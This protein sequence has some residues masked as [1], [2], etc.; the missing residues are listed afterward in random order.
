MDLYQ[1]LANKTR[2]LEQKYTKYII[3]KYSKRIEEL[4]Q[5]NYNKNSEELV[6]TKNIQELNKKNRELENKLVL[7]NGDL[8]NNCINKELNSINLKQEEIVE[9]IKQ[10][11]KEVENLRKENSNLIRELE[12]LRTKNNKNKEVENNNL[13]KELESLRKE[14]NNLFK[15]V[16]SLKTKNNGN[17]SKEVDNLR[18]ENNNLLKEVESLRSK[19]NK[20]ISKEVETN[21]NISKEVENNNLL[22]NEKIIK[23]QQDMILLL[24][25]SIQNKEKKI[26]QQFEEIKKLEKKN[27]Q[28]VLPKTEI[29]NIKNNND[30][31]ALPKLENLKEL[32]PKNV[33]KSKVD[34]GKIIK[35]EN[36]SYFNDLSFSNSSPVEKSFRKGFK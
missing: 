35:E 34:V 22:K 23:E 13:F 7:N 12:T 4:T 30:P 17:I 29:E 11:N 1:K 26:N 6:L 21:K 33:K 27:E 32:K 8:N 16:E 14:N 24:K 3:E 36:K 25:D 5:E 18:K 28:W 19:N 15:E 20:N 2:N 10:I 31:W 9:L